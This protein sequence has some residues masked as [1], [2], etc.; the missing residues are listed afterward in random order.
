M[1][2]GPTCE[3]QLLSIKN[4]TKQRSPKQK[5]DSLMEPM[6]PAT[7]RS[8]LSFNAVLLHY[9]VFLFNNWATGD[10]FC[11]FVRKRRESDDYVAAFLKQE[12][13]QMTQL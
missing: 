2:A 7:P 3:K 10:Q 11:V 5:A 12:V 13:K 6:L 1:T 8:P 9:N 4:K